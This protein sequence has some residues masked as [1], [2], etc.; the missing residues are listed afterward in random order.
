MAR[1]T[2]NDV[3]YF[4]FICKEGKGMFIIEDKY[5]NNGFATWIKIIRSLATT[6][7][8]YLNLSDPSEKM[9]LSAKCKVS[10]S[11]LESIIDDLINLG[12]FDRE[13]WDDFSILYSE[14]FIE[15]IKDAYSKRNNDPLSKE[16]LLGHLLSLGVNKPSNS[17]PKPSNVTLKGVS[18][19]QSKVKESK[20]EEKK[21]K[22]IKKE[23]FKD[24]NYKPNFDKLF[25][26]IKGRPNQDWITEVYEQRKQETE[27]C[28][29]NASLFIE[30]T[31]KPSL[32]EF[33]SSCR[34]YDL[35]FFNETA[36]LNYYKKASKGYI[37]DVDTWRKLLKAF[38]KRI[39][40]KT[41]DKY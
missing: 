22:E 14:K 28:G 36:C 20:G 9:F 29:A 34:K 31:I 13:L 4:P 32:Y 1:P 27:T 24:R 2:R 39:E 17:I 21:E 7:F 6:N 11:V 25:V 23:E 33:C 37:D 3:D 15:G 5:G 40:N 35:D 41:I 19:P 30:K 10:Q 16:A 26:K 8:H 38:K 18:N 12:E